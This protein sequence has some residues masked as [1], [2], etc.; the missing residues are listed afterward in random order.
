MSSENKEKIMGQRKDEI[1]KMFPGALKGVNINEMLEL[2]D[3]K[4]V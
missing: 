4:R 3:E 1:N 2:F